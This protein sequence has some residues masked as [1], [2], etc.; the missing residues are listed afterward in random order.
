MKTR[1]TSASF[2]LFLIVALVYLANGRSIGS[3]DTLPARYLPF[4][5]LRAH[6]FNL[7]EFPLLY[8]EGAL[9]TFPVQ[10]G[11]PYF[12]SYRDGHYFSA[13]SP[14]PGVLALPVYVLPV[15]AGVPADMW[16]PALEKLSATAITALSVVFL[17][18]ALREMVGRRW[19]L[20]IAAIY[21]FGTSSWSAS[22]QALWQHGPSQL[23]LTLL[24]VC[25]VRGMKD[26]RFLAYAGFTMSAATVM[27][28][29]DLLIVLPVVVYLVWTHPRL[30]PRLA[31]FALPPIVGLLLYNLVCLGSVA[32]GSGNITAPTWALFTQVPMVRGLSGVLVSPSRGLF[33][34][35]PVLLF[36]V[37]GLLRVAFRGPTLFKPVAAGVVVM[38][39]VVG[40][41]FIWWGGHSWGPR[42]LADAAPIF[43]FF[44]YPVT[45]F[46]DRYRLLKGM[47][48][49]LAA[50]SVCAHGLGAFCYD[51]RWDDDANVGR[52]DAA[53]WS[54][55]RGP[56]VFYCGGVASVVSRIL[57]AGVGGSPT[58]ADSRAVLAASYTVTP[59]A[60]E[61]FIGE[62]I[63]VSV[64][65]RN[66]GQAVWLA[67]APGDL[68][69][70][71]L[72]WRWSDDNVEVAAG[73]VFLSSDVFPGQVA[74]FVA[75][76]P[77][78]PHPGDYRLT[79]HLVSELVTWF[80]GQGHEPVNVGIRV[81]R[82]EL[83]HFLV[84]PVGAVGP[85]PTATIST[86]RVSYQRGE[87]LRLSVEARNSNYPPNKFDVYV[88]RQGPGGAEWFYGHRRFRAAEGAWIALARGLP[89]PAV[90]IG[91]F[92]LPLSELIPGAYRWHVV[93][94]EAG[95]L[96]PLAKAT[97]AFSLGP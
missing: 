5:L 82:V 17:F 94:T 52:S 18:W 57:S 14:G 70:V 78:P 96:R 45:G 31:L 63:V 4:S 26:E 25:L 56:L 38:I 61:A 90:V 87:T 20:G 80:A 41:W 42:L 69:S 3:G 73:R 89:M 60:A 71:R 53:L 40:K 59:I 51:G 19:A 10:E 55:R 13:Y 76:I 79:I 16:A 27:R 30:M 86:D 77:P 47:F 62:T 32:G 74:R 2:L 33:V 39:L 64:E 48:V 1:L 93:L 91:R 66:T 81:R 8:G 43:C 85:I 21:A 22:S 92:S 95:T 49:L 15:L 9:R 7:D 12:L 75:R 50:L 11:I 34:Y 83:E 67:S 97:A 36:S 65:A 35:S 24:L 84:E 54:W 28:S 46:L 88:L 6:D 29:T 72:G 58:S 44:L 37:V 68:G 23:F